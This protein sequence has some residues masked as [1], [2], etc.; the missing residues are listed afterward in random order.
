[1]SGVNVLA[2]IDLEICRFAEDVAPGGSDEIQLN[3]FKEARDAVADLIEKCEAL[4]LT[5]HGGVD[6][7]LRGR[8][9]DVAAALARFTGA[10]A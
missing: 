4:A 5:P 7:V 10:Q 3:Q 2:V 1:M 8:I 9:A 6:S